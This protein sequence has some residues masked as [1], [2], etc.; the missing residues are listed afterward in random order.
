VLLSFRGFSLQQVEDELARR[1]GENQT[2]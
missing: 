1:H 2:P